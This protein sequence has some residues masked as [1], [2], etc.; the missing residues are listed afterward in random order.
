MRY[1]RE[2][3]MSND[4]GNGNEKRKRKLKTAFPKLQ[5]TTKRTSSKNNL[6]K[7]CLGRSG[8][9]QGFS[10]ELTASLAYSSYISLIEGV[11]SGVGRMLGVA[12]LPLL[13]LFLVFKFSNLPLNLFFTDNSA[14]KTVIRV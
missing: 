6:N 12:F 14:F 4:K 11:F 2:K 10:L 5:P 7:R 1:S 13:G 3:G 8:W 9:P